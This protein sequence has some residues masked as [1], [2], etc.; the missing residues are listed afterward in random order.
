MTNRGNTNLEQTQRALSSVSTLPLEHAWYEVRREKKWR[1][2]ALV[3]ATEGLRIFRTAMGFAHMSSRESAQRVLVVNASL[4]SCQPSGNLSGARVM[5]GFWKYSA[6]SNEGEPFTRCD[7][8]DLALPD[9][10]KVLSSLPVEL[11]GLIGDAD[12]TTA[13]FAVDSP[14]SQTRSIGLLRAVDRVV[15]FVP[16]G[17]AEFRATRQIIDIIGSEKV[18]GA[19]AVKLHS[20]P[21]PATRIE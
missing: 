14:I 17:L 18:M 20:S 2:L 3:P 19:V 16:L 1:S 7:L 15:I 12:Y 10:E 8:S 21:R 13:I 6:G 9:A 5:D 4:A 11:P